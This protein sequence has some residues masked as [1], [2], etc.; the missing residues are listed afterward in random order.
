M[1]SSRDLDIVGNDCI[2]NKS[3]VTEKKFQ[4]KDSDWHYHNAFQLTL[5]EREEASKLKIK[6]HLCELNGNK[7]RKLT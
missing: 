5:L 1:N 3:I 2:I 6:N 4:L 7:L